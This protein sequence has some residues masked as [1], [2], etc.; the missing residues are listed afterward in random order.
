MDNL[1]NLKKMQC[2]IKQLKLFIRHPL[3]CK[4]HRSPFKLTYVLN[5]LL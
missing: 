5:N 2:E 3:A 4:Y 1:D